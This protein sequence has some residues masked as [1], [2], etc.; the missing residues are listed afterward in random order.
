MSKKDTYA[1][2][3]KF[4][5]KLEHYTATSLVRYRETLY[6]K[7]RFKILIYKYSYGAPDT[8]KINFKWNERL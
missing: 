2:C 3:N 7:Y 6:Q 1:L 5:E 8:Y 4:Y